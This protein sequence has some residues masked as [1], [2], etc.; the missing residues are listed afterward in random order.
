MTV[1]MAIALPA[2]ELL[3]G[4]RYDRELNAWMRI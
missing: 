2:N 4:A 3:T 1:R